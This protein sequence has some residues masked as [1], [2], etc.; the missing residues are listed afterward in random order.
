MESRE[1]FQSSHTTSSDTMTDDDK[2]LTAS[3]LAYWQT[4]MRWLIPLVQATGYQVVIDNPKSH[5]QISIDQN[6]KKLPELTL[7]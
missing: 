6:M 7:D 4:Q 1:R 3:D 5:E 2:K